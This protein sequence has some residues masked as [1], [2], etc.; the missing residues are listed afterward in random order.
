VTTLVRL[1]GAKTVANTALR[2]IPL[3]LPTLEGAFGATTRQMT[4]VIGV[5][6][7]AGFSTIAS[8]V[9]LDQGRER[10]VMVS[11]LGLIAASA[12]IALGGTLTTFAVSFFVLVLGVGNFTVAGQA[13]ISHRVPYRQRAR[14]LGLFETSWAIALLVGAPVIALLITMLGWRAPFVALAVAST[15][16]ALIVA[17][18]LPSWSRGPDEIDFVTAS[19]GSG[20]ST[21]PRASI[22]TTAWLVMLGSAATA[23]AGLAVFVVSGAWLDDAFGV[24]TGGIGLI[25]VGFGS[26]ELAGSLGSAGVADALGKLRSTMV[27]LVLLLLGLGVMMLADGRLP[28]GLGGLL[29]F[30]LGFEFAFVTS[31]SLVSE[32]MPDARGTTLAVSNAV[33]TIARAGGAILSGWLFS[34]HGIAGT[35]SL[36]AISTVTA[37]F[38]LVL[39]RRIGPSLA[40]MASTTA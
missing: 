6:E 38:A 4:T 33:A 19:D 22:T 16:A 24:S 32:A 31:L 23:M 30:L 28:V 40:P 18:S 17:R 36:S 15:I 29:L 20:H 34:T 35:A 26:V 39:S 10:V 11:S 2:W 9:R 7:L 1:T 14:S 5:G 8:G 25:A 27:G 12:I 3:F 13:W 37:A 21:T